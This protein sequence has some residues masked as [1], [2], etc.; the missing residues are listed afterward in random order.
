MGGE[1]GYLTLDER[2]RMFQLREARQPV[3]LIA[4]T[5]GRHKSTIYRELRR[6]I[7]REEGG[8]WQGYF[9]VTGDQF[10]RDRRQRLGKLTARADLL[11]HVIDR[12]QAGWSPQQIAGR[13][14]QSGSNGPDRVCHETIYRFVYGGDGRERDLYRHLPKGRRT[15]RRRFGRKPRQ[16]AIPN[17]HW[18]ANRPEP[19]AMREE[20]GHW[21]GDLLI[22]ARQNG[23]GNVTTL[24]ERK[25][26]YTVLLANPD[27]RSSGVIGA[28]Q[29][30]FA[31]LPPA[32]RQTITVDRGTEF[33]SYP[34]L[35]GALSITSY[36]CDPHSPWQKGAV[37][38]TNGRIRRY[39]P[40]DALPDTMTD[41]ALRALT[42]RLNDTPR[43]CLDYRTPSEVFRAHLAREHEQNI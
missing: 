26:R 33:M 7:F 29:S 15:R 28:V 38:N 30:V 27:R 14:K 21:E 40:S 42:K 39:L 43:R 36:F 37:E 25:S 20:F 4:A 16:S 5:L 11:D 6:N 3:G 32:G 2:R 19:I 22:F 41:D 31:E 13:L 12:L 9:P 23:K 17:A 8:A 24:L 35:A 18:I 34:T 10:A 1:Y